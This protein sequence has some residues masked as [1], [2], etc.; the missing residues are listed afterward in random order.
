MLVISISLY[1]LC[2][3]DNGPSLGALGR[4]LYAPSYVPWKEYFN[5]NPML[6][7]QIQAGIKAENKLKPNQKIKKLLKEHMSLGMLG[8]KLYAPSDVSWS[9]LFQGNPML[10]A[11]IQAG[12]K[13]ENRQNPNQH[14]KRLLDYNHGKRTEII[15]YLPNSYYQ[16]RVQRYYEP[17]HS[18]RGF[19][20]QRYN[21]LY[22]Y[23][24]YYG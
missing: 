6:M 4:K 17:P 20:G 8:S 16:T 2:A 22:K 13:L 14:I 10:M 12:M 11:Q 3:D 18:P 5:V 15:D 1:C 24:Y 21:L 7:A 9:E 19:H 23:R